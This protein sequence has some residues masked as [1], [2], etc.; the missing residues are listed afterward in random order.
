MVPVYTKGIA[1]P[2]TGNAI[3]S[4]TENGKTAT[5][6]LCTN[7]F[8]KILTIGPGYSGDIQWETYVTDST[9]PVVPT[10]TT[11]WTPIPGANSSSYVITEAQAGKNY[12][13]AKFTNG[14]CESTKVYSTPIAIYYKGQDQDCGGGTTK[15]VPD[16]TPFDV[17]VYPNPFNDSFNLKLTTS[18]DEKVSIAVYD[19]IGKV[20]EQRQMNPADATE[21]QIGG[22]YPTGV[23][24]LIFSQGI[25][26]KILRVIKK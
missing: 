3:L 12:F 19:M 5:M 8:S 18:S 17:I 14:G 7:N 22:N 25:E 26:T 23:Y 13:R 9:L 6:A 21:K 1:K 20:I 10:S 24:N 4:K 15:M 16:E 11:I 2:I